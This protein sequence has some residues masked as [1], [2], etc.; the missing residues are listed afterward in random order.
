MSNLC[1]LCQK[2]ETALTC[3]VCA[4]A[5]CKYCAHILEHDAF[6]FVPDLAPELKHGVYCNTCFD[7]RVA[8]ELERY[9]ECMERARNVEC[10]FRTQG[11]ESRLIKRVAKPV[12][13]AECFDRDELLMRLAFCAARSNFNALVDLDL[14]SEKVGK[15]S[16]QKLK[17]KGTGT[18]A[19]ATARS[20]VHDKSIWHNPN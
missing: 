10:F 18:P 17:W 8:G 14:V 6:L 13:V 15:G 19:N 20:V 16:Y 2:N 11:K 12:T 5:A 3:G 4:S 7:A 1:S 9:N